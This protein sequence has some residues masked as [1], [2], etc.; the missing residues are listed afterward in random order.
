VTVPAGVTFLR[1]RIA[2]P[3]PVVYGRMT[4]KA[5]LVVLAG[6]LLATGVA[7]QQFTRGR[8]LDVRLAAPEDY[9]GRFTFCRLMYTSVRREEGGV[10]WVTDYPGADANL[11]IRLS[12]LTHTAISQQPGGQPNHLVVR[13]TDPMLFQCPTLQMSDAGTAGFSGEEIEHLRA[14]LQ[15]G[16]FIWADDFWGDAA[17][18]HLAAELARILPPDDYPI[19]DL[20]LS[21]PVFRTMFTVNRAPQI[22]SI[23]IWRPYRVTSERGAETATVNVRG[24]ADP[25]GRL[26]VLMT[27][28][29][30][31][32]DAWEREVDDPDYFQHFSPEGYAVGINVMLYAMTH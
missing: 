9:D 27:H 3:A 25:H 30:D 23:R 4:R 18:A 8:A 1:R 22:P 32:Q 6:A 14:Y 17:F 10:G 16:G 26:M 19:V 24:I 28:N 11:S 15:K 21:H 20:P 13:A 5:L 7:A 2:P 29:T 12:E 31:I